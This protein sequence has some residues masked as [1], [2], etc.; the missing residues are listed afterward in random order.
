[1]L[2]L[3]T[4]PTGATEGRPAYTTYFGA[5]LAGGIATSFYLIRWRHV[6]A[7]ERN[8]RRSSRSYE[9]DS[10]WITCFPN[11]II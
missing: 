10:S 3:P 4:E 6:K 1:M 8:A 11:A 7:E 5:T 2:G 9:A